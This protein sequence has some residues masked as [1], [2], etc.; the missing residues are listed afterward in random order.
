[1]ARS[2]GQVSCSGTLHVAPK[3]A[4][5]LIYIKAS[6]RIG[7]KAGKTLNLKTFLQLSLHSIVTGLY[8]TLLQVHARLGP[9]LLR[10]SYN[11]DKTCRRQVSLK[12][13]TKACTR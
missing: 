4:I 2:M 13:D 10:T 8:Q 3:W 7:K 11:N 12:M 9:A 1:M 6:G 5:M